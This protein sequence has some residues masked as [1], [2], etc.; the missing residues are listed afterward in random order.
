MGLVFRNGK[1]LFSGGKLAL[2]TACCCASCPATNGY[3]W[4]SSTQLSGGPFSGPGQVTS[5]ESYWPDYD[6]DGWM[7]WYAIFNVYSWC[8]QSAYDPPDTTEEDLFF[9]G[10]Y[11]FEACGDTVDNQAFEDAVNAWLDDNGYDPFDIVDNRVELFTTE[12]D[13]SAYIEG[14]A[15]D[16]DTAG[17]DGQLQIIFRREKLECPC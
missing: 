4:I 11:Y 1:P 8:C 6:P 9:F 15:E 2:S 14:V 10:H 17:E 3:I 5:L 16:A 7:Q 13:I 12:D